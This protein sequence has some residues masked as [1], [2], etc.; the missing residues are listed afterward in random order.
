MGTCLSAIRWGGGAGITEKKKIK[1]AIQDSVKRDTWEKIFEFFFFLFS[2]FPYS[3]APRN[4]LHS[5]R[6]CLIFFS[7]PYF[8]M[9]KPQL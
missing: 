7:C 4:F 1:I 3:L 8:K 9:E 6:P 2:Y 5:E